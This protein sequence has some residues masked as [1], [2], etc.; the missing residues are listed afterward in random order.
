M[1]MPSTIHV[2]QAK[3]DI[4]GALA[5]KV[6]ELAEQAIREHRRFTVALSGGS[7]M[8]I[9]CPAL[10]SDPL[11]SRIDWTAWEVFWADERCVPLENPESNFAAAK[12]LLFDHVSIPREQIHA[13]ED[14]LEPAAAASA[15][16]AR[17]KEFFQPEASQLP[18]F[19]LILLGM[20]QDGHT[21]SLFPGHELLHE[22]QKWVA[23]IFDAP[24]PP[25]QRITLT[26]PVI[27]H[28][29]EVIFVVAGEGKAQPL[30]AVFDVQSSDHRP[31]AALVNP[32]RGNV[33]W[34][35]DSAAAK[36]LTL[37]PD[38]S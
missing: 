4:S 9:L 27:N 37:L 11:R 20:G 12:M 25:P 15:Y 16:Q 29:R 36:N 35:V 24:K 6:A 23:P 18:R 32:T 2:S 7:L 19:D 26:L 21:A 28:A 22:E 38:Q 5:S 13:L 17:L 3:T 1:T 34:F 10:V 8:D 31:P 30:Q 33:T 14:S